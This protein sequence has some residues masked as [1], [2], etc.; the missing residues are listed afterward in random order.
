MGGLQVTY[1]CWSE[2]SYR[3]YKP[4]DSGCI[5]RPDDLIVLVEDACSSSPVFNMAF[6]EKSIVQLPD[7]VAVE[8]SLQLITSHS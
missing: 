4:S 1:C 3:L 5:D 2:V 6:E 8:E 7:Y